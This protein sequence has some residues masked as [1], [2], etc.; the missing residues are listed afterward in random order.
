MNSNLNKAKLFYK[1]A[2]K[3]SI[4][5]NNPIEVVKTMVNELTKSMNVVIS[6]TGKKDQNNVR[7][8]HFSRALVI[9]YTLQTSL[10][11]EKGEALAGKLFQ[12]Y[13][14]CRKQLINCFS[15]KIIDGVVKAVNALNDIFV[16][17]RNK[18]VQPA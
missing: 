10:D 9:I 16:E 7:A 15:H 4:E 6:S 3:S 17:S 8:K 18:N 12:I 5:N 2:E 11:F 1:K 13:E 14:Y